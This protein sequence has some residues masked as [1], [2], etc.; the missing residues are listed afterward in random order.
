MNLKQLM[1]TAWEIAKQA[2]NRFGG[3]AVQYMAGALKKAWEK[4][5]MQFAVKQYNDIRKSKGDQ[6]AN[7]FASQYIASLNLD[8]PASRG[9]I[10]ESFKQQGKEEQA[11]AKKAAKAEK[12][13][14]KASINNTCKAIIEKHNPFGM[15]G[16]TLKEHELKFLED[17]KTK[18]KLTTRQESWLRALASKTD[19]K[20]DGT[21]ENRQNMLEKAGYKETA[22]HCEHGDLGSLGYRHGDTVKCPFCGQMAEVW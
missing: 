2:A 15:F 22:T 6:Q 7:E 11:A 3:K 4:R 18:R 1:T 19:V 14:N 10:W 13:K 17:M 8:T 9:K 5:K 16:V 20:I 12:K 21:F